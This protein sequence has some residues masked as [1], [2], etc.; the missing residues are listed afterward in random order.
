MGVST[1]D[2]ALELHEQALLVAAKRARS[3]ANTLPCRHAQF[4]RRVTWTLPALHATQQTG[5]GR[6]FNTTQ[7]L[8]V[9]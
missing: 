5:E 7:T 4:S 8:P 1:L 2:K 9:I 6:S 3:L